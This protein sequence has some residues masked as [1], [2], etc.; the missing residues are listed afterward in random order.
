MGAIN[1]YS[2]DEFPGA[3]TSIEANLGAGD[4]TLFDTFAELT[5]KIQSTD[6]MPLTIRFGRAYTVET[7]ANIEGY[8]EV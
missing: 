6:G 4:C 3:V 7:V 5:F 2:G 8:C 1:L